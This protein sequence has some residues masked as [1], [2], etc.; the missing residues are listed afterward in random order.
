MWSKMVA[1]CVT[2]VEVLKKQACWG[3]FRTRQAGADPCLVS[4]RCLCKQSVFKVF[5]TQCSRFP[6]GPYGWTLQLHVLDLVGPKEEECRS[7]ELTRV[8]NSHIQENPEDKTLSTSC[9]L[10]S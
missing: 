8:D 9:S 1:R 4:E 6:L 3:H 7:S 2:D 5:A 10:A